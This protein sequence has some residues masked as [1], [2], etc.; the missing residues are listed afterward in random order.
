MTYQVVLE[1]NGGES[2]KATVLGWPDCYAEGPTRGEALEKVR[3]T[4]R[5]R[6]ARVEIVPVE[7]EAV[8]DEESHW[9][10][11]EGMFKD[12][13]LFEQVIEYMEADRR[14][15]DSDEEAV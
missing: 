8:G 14:E 9:R 11:Y 13:P 2:F 5:Q 10:K 15:L 4:L 7:I 1:Q 6:L 12:N 3:D